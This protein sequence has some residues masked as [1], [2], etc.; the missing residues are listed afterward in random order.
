[1][2][3]TKNQSISLRLGWIALAFL[4]FWNPN[5]SVFDFLP[6]FIGYLLLSIGL[7]KIADLNESIEDALSLFRKMILVDLG[8]WLAILWIFGLGTPAEQSSSLLL[9]TFV[10]AVAEGIVLIPAYTKLFYGITQLGY[11]FPNTSIF[12]GE[13]V[14]QKKS[15][16]DRAATFAKVFVILKGT[17]SV[18]PELAELTKGDY[19]EI[20]SANS[21]YPYIGIMRLMAFLPILILGIVWCVSMISYF[22]RLSGDTP[23]TD[24]LRKKYVEAVLPKG[25]LFVQRSFNLSFMLLMVGA[26]LSADLR[27]ENRNMLPDFLCSIAIFFVFFFLAKHVETKKPLW[28]TVTASH[29]LLSVVGY[30]TELRFFK[31]FTYSAILRNEEARNAYILLVSCNLLKTV[32]F[33]AMIWVLIRVLY[34]TVTTHTGYVLGREHV[35]DRETK[36]IEDLHKEQWRSLLYTF[37]AALLYGISDVFFD[38]LSPDYGFMGLVNLVFATIFVI[39]AFKTMSQIQNAIETK[40]MLE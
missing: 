32:A 10:F 38:F 11:F 37:V 19:S 13:G 6:D 20:G 29:L 25:G 22:R 9:F 1:M 31:E 3:R 26:V 16:T 14:T 12:S 35:G 5:V 28:I 21:L 17:F 15:R 34:T 33:V 18:L 23:L 27:L 8:K 30:V 2:N 36:M 40:Y 39:V 4:F 7:S 24:G